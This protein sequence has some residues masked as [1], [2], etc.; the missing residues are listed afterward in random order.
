MAL[1][2]RLEAVIESPREIP[3]FVGPLSPPPWPRFVRL[4]GETSDHDVALV[5]A[6]LATYG[7]ERFSRFV[8]LRE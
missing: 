6:Q 1:F 4:S 7:A 5:V 2:P 3:G 8:S